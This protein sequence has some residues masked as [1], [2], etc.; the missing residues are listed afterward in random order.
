MKWLSAVTLQLEA[1]EF[2]A[3]VYASSTLECSLVLA[4]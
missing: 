1:E 3:V 2:T 4:N